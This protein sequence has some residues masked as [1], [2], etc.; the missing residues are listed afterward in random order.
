MP[1]D[2]RRNYGGCKGYAV[3]KENGEV[4]GC[5]STRGSALNHQQ[6][7]YASEADKSSKLWQ[8]KIIPKRGKPK[9][10]E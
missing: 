1:W 2:I 7:L 3:V 6:A 5:H 4:V 8:G 9:L 10:S